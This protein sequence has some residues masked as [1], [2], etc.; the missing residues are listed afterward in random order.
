MGIG[1][2]SVA[3]AGVHG[4]GKQ[5]GFELLTVFPSAGTVGINVYRELCA[6]TL[7]VRVID[8]CHLHNDS[9]G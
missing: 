8:L 3:Q 1:P 2:W 9:G 5:P 6:I 7:R 4:V